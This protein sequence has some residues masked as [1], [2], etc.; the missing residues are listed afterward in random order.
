MGKYILYAVIIFIALFILN[1]F[2]II[3][4]PFLDMP[5]FTGAKEESFHKSQEK[6]KELK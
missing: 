1:W 5:D 2:K 6:V 3:N 4:I